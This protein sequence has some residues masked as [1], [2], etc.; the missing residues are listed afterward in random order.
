[1][2]AC[3][4]MR[5][6]FLGQEVFEKLGL[7]VEACAEHMR[8]S[9]IMRQYQQM[10][11]SRIVPTLKDIGLWGPRL[12]GAFADMGVLEFGEL[13]TEEQGRADEDVALEL[14]RL[15]GA[16]DCYVAQSP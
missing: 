15:R 13:N 16:R 8:T 7:D 14:E 11:F 2:E 9:E 1:V 3:Y 12:R 5:D 4:L 6:R 10:L